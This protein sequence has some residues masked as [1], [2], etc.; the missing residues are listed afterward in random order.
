MRKGI[1]ITGRGL[2]SSMVRCHFQAGGVNR[3]FMESKVVIFG[4]WRIS[5]MSIAAFPSERKFSIVG[6]GK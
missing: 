1:T 6:F 3:T 4:K 2:D 5:P